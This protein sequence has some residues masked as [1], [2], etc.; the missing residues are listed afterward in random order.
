MCLGLT[1]YVA[2]RLGCRPD[3]LTLDLVGQGCVAALPNLSA[4]E[5]LLA[6]GR[7]RRVLSIGVEVCSAA[8]YFADDPGVLISACLFGTHHE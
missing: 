6:A 3:V 2:E 5:A 8:L 7:R 4:S 1:S